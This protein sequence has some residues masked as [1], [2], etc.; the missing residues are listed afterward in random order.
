VAA[1]MNCFQNEKASGSA[2]GAQISVSWVHVGHLKYLNLVY[3]SDSKILQI[4]ID[5][6]YI[7]TNIFPSLGGNKMKKIILIIISLVLVSVVFA[8]IPDYDEISLRVNDMKTVKD[9]NI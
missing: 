4:S 1:K 9:N 8:N 2:A 6:L 3:T 5:N 7:L